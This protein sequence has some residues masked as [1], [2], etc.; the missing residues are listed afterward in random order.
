MPRGKTETHVFIVLTR[1]AGGG[2]RYIDLEISKPELVAFGHVATQWGFLEHLIKSHT[3]AMAK[4]VGQKMPPDAENDS[5]RR[6]LRVWAALAT[7]IEKLDP[8]YGARVLKIAARVREISGERHKLMHGRV[9]WKPSKT[10]PLEIVSRGK[11][12]RVN[13]E[14]IGETAFKISRIN[15]DLA[16][17]G[18]EQ[19]IVHDALPRKRGR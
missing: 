13:W 12:W 10:Q 18:G 14:R 2:K 1:D 16:S 17:V 6:R 11:S 8:E 7:E 3:R 4:R 9:V 15:Y 19:L 5:L